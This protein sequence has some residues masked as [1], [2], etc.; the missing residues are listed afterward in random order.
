MRARTWSGDPPLEDEHVAVLL[1]VQVHVE[2]HGR[3]LPAVGPEPRELLLELRAVEPSLLRP[4]KPC[5]ITVVVY[6]QVVMR[7]RI[8]VACAQPRLRTGP[9]ACYG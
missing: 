4:M 5:V 6:S 1:A 7:R 2:E 3:E 9:T 8:L